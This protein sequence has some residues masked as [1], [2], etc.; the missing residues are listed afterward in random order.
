[1]KTQPF[2]NLESKEAAKRS[3]AL[4]LVKLA[5]DTGTIIQS[6]IIEHEATTW[7]VEIRV[8]QPEDAPLETD[9]LEQLPE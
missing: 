4:S 6:F 1:M 9:F 2:Q 3:I 7:E 5:W 8:R